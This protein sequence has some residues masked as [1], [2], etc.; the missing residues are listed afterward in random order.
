MDTDSIHESEDEE[1]ETCEIG[2]Q[3]EVR[4]A[5]NLSGEIVPKNEQVLDYI[6]RSD[7]LQE[8]CLWEYVACIQKLTQKWVSYGSDNRGSLQQAD[9]LEMDMAF[10]SIVTPY[11]KYMFSVSHPDYESHIK[12]VCRP[13]KR[14]IPVP[15]GPLLPH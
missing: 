6:Q 15:I 8:V 4:I 9:E 12:Q 5:M 13:E 2:L 11:A 1:D 7:G 3:D 14:L 10:K